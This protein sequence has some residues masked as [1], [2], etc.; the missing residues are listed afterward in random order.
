MH[1]S[2][3]PDEGRQPLSR[4]TLAGGLGFLLGLA[5]LGLVAAI[6][7]GEPSGPAL[8]EERSANAATLTVED[9]Y[10]MSL[11]FAAVAERTTPGVVRIE[12]TRVGSASAASS[13][14]LPPGFEQ[15]FRSPIPEPTVPQLSGGTGFVMSDDG[16]IITNHHVVEDAQDITV[17]LAD[18]RSFEA[19]L[20][21]SDPTTDV[22]VL[23]IEADDLTPLPLGDSERVRVGEWVV[24]VGNPGFQGGRP[25]DETVTAGIVSA[26]GRPLTLIRNE[27]ARDPENREIAAWAIEDFIQ[28][29]AVINPG[30]SGGPLVNIE[31]EVVGMNTA[32]MSATGYY[33]GYG[34]AVPVNLVMGVAEDL[35][36][37]GTVRRGWI[38]LRISGVT[39]EDAEALG[40]ER[41]AGV[42]VQ[43]VTEGGP[44]EEAGLRFG[45]VIVEIEGE[46]VDRV[47]ALQQQVARRDPGSR[48][49]VQVVRDGKRR[50]LE[51]ELGLAPIEAAPQRA[52]SENTG[53][54]LL[55]A[56]FQELSP[57]QARQFGWER[58]GVLVAS[59]SPAG[60]SSRLGISPGTRVVSVNG[61]EIED[62]GDLNRELDSVEAGD[63][64]SMVLESPQGNRWMSNV[65][66]ESQPGGGSGR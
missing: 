65:R 50:T 29:D 52:R 37:N 15:F 53:H 31:G 64:V 61:S 63:V 47:G 5:V 45:D 24:A 16:Y 43:G 46:P 59:V 40:L 55:G 6:P 48:I 20:I 14:R 41:I 27:L 26:I 60:P 13:M 42:L 3:G 58:G 56:S 35:I 36:E 25:L 11:G 1:R 57:A 33:Q 51:V 2:E 7:G 66:A 4:T 8:G 54:G 23:R 30:N 34:F 62:L 21:G 22:A 19:E 17:W 39:A 12:T 44:A 49:E 28:T 10:D 9:P 38:G 18:R 32:I